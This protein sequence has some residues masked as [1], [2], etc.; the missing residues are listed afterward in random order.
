MSRHVGRIRT[1][2]AGRLAADSQR[3]EDYPV[4]PH[5]Y[6]WAGEEVEPADD[7]VKAWRAT[8]PYQAGDVVWVQVGDGKALRARIL[9]VFVHY[10]RFH[11]RVA[12]FR[13]VLETKKG[14]WAKQWI[15]TWPGFIQRGYAIAGLAPDVRLD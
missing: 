5:R 3:V 8:V 15:Y 11:E 9:H 1:V 13:I 14:L 12:Q 4:A 6:T 10:N 2:E 7:S